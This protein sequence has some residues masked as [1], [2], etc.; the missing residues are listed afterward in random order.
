[1]TSTDVTHYELA[2]SA[3]DFA[4]VELVRIYWKSASSFSITKETRVFPGLV[5]MSDGA[6]EVDV[7]SIGLSVPYSQHMYAQLSSDGTTVTTTPR[8]QGGYSNLYAVTG[9]YPVG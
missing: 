5:T 3:N 9:L 4:L 7:A 6:V 8:L 2:R 1:M